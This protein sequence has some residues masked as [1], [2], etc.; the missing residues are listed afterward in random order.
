MVVKTGLK[1]TAIQAPSASNTLVVQRQLKECVEVG[2][3]LRG[4]P[5]D[6]FV[7]VSELVN[8]G[9]MRLVNGTLQP[10]TSSSLPGAVVPASRQIITVGSIIGGGDLSA[11]RTLQ[12]SGDA[13]S[14]GSS[15]LYGTNSSG[16]KGWYAQ[17]GGGGGSGTV[18]SVGL[19]SS[20]FAVS[21]SPVTVSGNITANL[22]AQGGLAAGSY[23]NANITVNS[24]GIVTAAAN[25]SGGGGGTPLPASIAGLMYWFQADVLTQV[26]GDSIPYMQNSNPLFPGWGAA[27]L[28][29]SQGLI[30]ATQLNGKNVLNI[31]GNTEYTLAPGALLPSSTVFVVLNPNA[32]GSYQTFFGSG[33]VNSLQMTI[34]PSGNV[35]I[36]A[37]GAAVIGH[38]TGVLSVGTAVQA[39]ST[40]DSVSGAYAF[41]ISQAASGSGS[42]TASI[43]NPSTGVGWNPSS[44]QPLNA[45][46]AEL[47]VYNRVLTNTEITNVEA[48]LH[49]KWGV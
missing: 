37:A 2:Q 30:G 5:N 35:E 49:T 15:M 19:L 6:S 21:G 7:R 16:V 47:I 14:P 39:N 27:N 24:K 9:I 3:R 20:D 38:S 36:D 8:A 17:P 13:A 28:A 11:D 46:M 45:T 33:S 12:L 31:P 43:T 32:I 41:R 42:G 4:D 29:G 10:P 1:T 25:G 18:T 44:S 23:T 48:Y 40:W 22:A 26:A 34:N